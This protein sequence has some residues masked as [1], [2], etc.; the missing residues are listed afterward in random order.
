VTDARLA[1]AEICADLRS[2]E[3]LDPAFDRHASKLDARDRRWVRELVYGMLRRRAHLDALLNQRE[4]GGESRL[5][6]DLID[7]LRLGAA[8]LLYMG[9]VPAYAASAQTVELAKRRHGLGAC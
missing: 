7:H 2:G 4:R 3:L 8:Q 1:A 5:D 9:R 6:P